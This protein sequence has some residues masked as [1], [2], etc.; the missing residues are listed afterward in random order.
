MEKA[1]TPALSAGQ[2][3]MGTLSFWKAKGKGTLIGQCILDDDGCMYCVM[4][5][6]YVLRFRQEE[7]C[8]PALTDATAC[9][10]IALH[11]VYNNIVYSL[12][13]RCLLYVCRLT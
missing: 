3:H 7:C 11:R 1:S 5:C 10:L 6:R 4:L 9:G 8:A 2:V 12:E 13:H